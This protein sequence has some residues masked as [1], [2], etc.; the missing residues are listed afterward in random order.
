MLKRHEDALMNALED[1]NAVGWVEIEWWKLYQWY[2]AERLTKKIYRDLRTRYLEE[3]EDVELYLYDR[4]QQSLL[5]V[6]GE[7]LQSFSEKLG[8]AEE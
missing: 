3:G 7:G 5:I 1:L 2:G 6:M 4:H 8:E